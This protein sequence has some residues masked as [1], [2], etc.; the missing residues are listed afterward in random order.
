M[1]IN[2]IV[3][4]THS[5]VDMHRMMV[6][7]MGPPTHYLVASIILGYCSTVS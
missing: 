5:L 2:R 6:M 4:A 7:K 1:P 3:C